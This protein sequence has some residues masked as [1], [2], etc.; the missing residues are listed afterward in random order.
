MSGGRWCWLIVLV[1][2]PGYYKKLSSKQIE[3][4]LV[5]YRFRFVSTDLVA[6]LLGKDRSTIYESFYNLEKQDY[7]QK[8]YEKSYNLLG[9][10]AIYCLAAKGIRFLRDNTEIDEKRLRNYYKNKSA[11]NELI[12][13]YMYV[14]KVFLK[15]RRQFGDRFNIHTR[16]D[17]NKEAFPNPLPELWLER[18]QEDSEG[19]DYV[20]DIFPALIPSWLLRRRVRQYQDFEDESEY[21]S[22]HVLCICGNESTEKRLFKLVYE[23]YNEFNFY[24]TQKELFDSGEDDICIDTEQAD[25]DEIER[26]SLDN[27]AM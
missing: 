5:L 2:D 25:E 8:F 27:I 24:L 21:E 4:L 14:F 19:L 13:K 15:L 26:V 18:K 16:A 6:E 1:K 11:D 3:L 17:M 23:N 20:L 22:S 10:P 7:I 12:D 9:R